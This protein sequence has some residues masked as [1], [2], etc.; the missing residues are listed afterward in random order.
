M[1][2]KSCEA[3]TNLAEARASVASALFMPRHSIP[4]TSAEMR[5]ASRWLVGHN[6]ALPIYMGSEMSRTIS[7]PS[8][9]ENLVCIS[10]TITYLFSLAIPKFQMGI[11]F[12]N[13]YPSFSDFKTLKQDSTDD[14]RKK[15][16]WNS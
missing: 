15:D 7:L 14:I 9:L 5:L 2:L 16:S 11:F 10:N 13:P 6:F 3:K 1:E 12:L 4:R 8:I